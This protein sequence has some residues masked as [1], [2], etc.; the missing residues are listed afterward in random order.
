MK[1]V[2]EMKLGRPLINGKNRVDQ[3]INSILRNVSPDGY[4]SWDNRGMDWHDIYFPFPDE[5]KDIQF[6][7]KNWTFDVLEDFA[8]V[9]LQYVKDMISH[10]D[11]LKSKDCSKIIT[12]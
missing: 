1:V 9:L 4:A 3:I 10:Y 2:I 8:I 6:I 7:N 12:L 11:E 5:L